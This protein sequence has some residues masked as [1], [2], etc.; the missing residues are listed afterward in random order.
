MLEKFSS[1]KVWIKSGDV[2]IKIN[3]KSFYVFARYY[4]M[5]KSEYS[6]DFFGGGAQW[7][8]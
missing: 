6:G 7:F 4:A 2:V 5:L 8:T 1:S 3:K